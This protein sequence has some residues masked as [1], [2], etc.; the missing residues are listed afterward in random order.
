MLS[1]LAVSPHCHPESPLTGS[2][3]PNMIAK[4]KAL[5]RTHFAYTD[6][7][8]LSSCL[9]AYEQ[10]KK[11]GLKFIPGI[12]IFFKDPQCPFI[13]GSSADRCKYFNV[14]LYCRDQEAY[15]ALVKMV[16][17]TDFPTIEIYE[18]NQQLWCWKDLEAISKYNVDCVIGGIHCMVGKPMLAGAAEAGMN[19]MAK[20]KELFG[21][22]LSTALVAEPWTKKWSNVI[23]IR[24]K[25]GTTDTLLASDT[26]TTDRAR[27]IKA[28]DLI[29]RKGH[30]FIKS[31]SKGMAFYEIGKEF[32][33]AELHKGF[34]PLPGGDAMTKINKF[35][36]SL[37]LKYKVFIIVSDY[38]YY[39]SKEDKIVQT[40]RLEG[41]NKLQPN[42]YMKNR[43]EIEDYLM[44]TLGVDVI[45]ASAYVTNNE[46]WAKN[47]DNFV[48]KYDWRLAKTE[49]S[50]IQL[51]MKISKDVG[52]MKW[53]DPIYMARLKEELAVIHSNGVY[54]LSPY[55]LPIRDVLNHYKEQGQLTGPG[56]GLCWRLTPLLHHWHYPC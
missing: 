13:A 10:C 2:T 7:G 19:V 16:S 25:D 54:D 8:H 4:A 50:A 6:Q 35:I 42:L 53:D 18:Q 14:S 39:A 41:N 23:K 48:L 26:V 43:D 28:M 27:R 46:N 29:E 31:M 1:N 38:A 24:Y 32:D 11:K 45:S 52:R 36:W 12:E 21:E 37:S 3:L 22:K 33:Y 5:G 40:M 9:K 56:R 44:H 30:S 47:Y 20:L 34:L 15:Q 55:F 17:R 49:G 51:L